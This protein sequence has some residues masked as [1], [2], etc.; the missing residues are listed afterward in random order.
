MSRDDKR[1]RPD[2]RKW[3]YLQRYFY[4][5]DMLRTTYPYDDPWDAFTSAL[6]HARKRRGKHAA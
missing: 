5:Y 4:F 2:R 6:K 3:S 1:T